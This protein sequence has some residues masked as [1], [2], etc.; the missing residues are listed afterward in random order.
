MIKF[1]HDI[2]AIEIHKYYKINRKYVHNK[3]NI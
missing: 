3:G 2:N 1:Y